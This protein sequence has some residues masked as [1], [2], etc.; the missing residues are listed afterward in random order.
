MK[1]ALILLAGP[2]GTGK[3]YFKN[4]IMA[5][6]DNFE[7][8]SVDVFKERLYDEIGFDNLDEKKVIDDNALY[9]F[10]QKVEEFM[11]LGKSIIHL[12]INNIVSCKDLVKSMGILILQCL[13]MLLMMCCMSA[14][15]LEIKMKVDI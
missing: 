1:K 2:P 7:S 3:T 8:T 9:L 12:A 10:F 6:N 13:C 15:S 14:K 11:T 4:M 5:R